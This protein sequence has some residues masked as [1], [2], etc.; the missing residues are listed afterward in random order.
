[1]TLMYHCT[2]DENE[3]M[4][5]DEDFIDIGLSERLKRHGRQQATR[6]HDKEAEDDDANEEKPE[7]PQ[8]TRVSS[9]STSSTSWTKK[10]LRSN[11]ERRDDPDN[12]EVVIF[13]DED[14]ATTKAPVHKIQKVES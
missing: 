9:V 12:E 7:P 6:L 11:S 13:D 3:E 14:E 10:L 1:M 8:P 2:E 5:Y 4:N